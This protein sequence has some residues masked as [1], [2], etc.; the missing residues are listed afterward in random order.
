MTFD[1]AVACYVPARRATRVDPI[2]A[3]RATLDAARRA[4]QLL[5]IHRPS[6]TTRWE[7]GALGRGEMRPSQG[8]AAVPG[9]TFVNH[10]VPLCTSVCHCSTRHLSAACSPS[11]C[12]VCAHPCCR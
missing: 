4:V 8:S 7:T 5:A 1:A 6:T 2:V 10:L 11:S 3:L 12:S 9:P